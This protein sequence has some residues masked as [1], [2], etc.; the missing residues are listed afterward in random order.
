MNRHNV[1]YLAKI[2]CLKAEV[3]NDPFATIS[4]DTVKRY[5][6]DVEYGDL[7]SVVTVTH[8]IES[9]RTVFQVFNETSVT[10]SPLPDDYGEPIVLTTY[11]QREHTR[12]PV[13][14][15][16]IDVLASDMFPVFKRPTEEECAVI[17]AMQ[18]VGGRKEAALKLPRMLDTE[19]VYK[20]LFRPEMQLRVVRF[21]RRNMFT[22]VEIAD[23]SVSVVLD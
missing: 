16:Y 23:R 12:F 9:S 20:I 7:V 8:K 5:D 17:A 21:L 19:L 14:M 15:L 4:R 11:M 13:F 18:R 1:R 6:I 10:Y 22:G 2:L 3:K